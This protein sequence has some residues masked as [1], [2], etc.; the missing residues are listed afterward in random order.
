MVVKAL[1]FD[2]DDT[3]LINDM[4]TFAPYYFRAL[5]AKVQRLCAPK[6]FLEALNAATRAMWHNDGSGGTN[7]EVFRREFFPRVR[8]KPEELMPLLEDFYARDFEA[9]SPYTDVDPEARVLV[10]LARQR[11]YQM[12]VATQPIFPLAAIK[13]RLRWAD[14]GD[15]EF[16]YDF[17]ASYETLS[18]CKPHPRYFGAILQSLGRSPRE[19]LMVGDSPEAD[20]AA[21]K[22]GFATFWVDRGRVESPE[23]VVS[24]ARGGLRELITLIETGR[25]DEL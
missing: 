2:L 17:I 25:I 21:G 9:L 18:A 20:M 7:A 14:V 11:G 1:L 24:D 5:A 22:Q 12:A 16:A 4:D 13:A 10:S 6:P 23:T 19:C 8:R 15:E 3:L